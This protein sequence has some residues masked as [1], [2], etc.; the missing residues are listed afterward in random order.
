MYCLIISFTTTYERKKKG[1]MPSVDGEAGLP[2]HTGE[3]VSAA[4][5]S[6]YFGKQ[7]V[8]EGSSHNIRNDR[9]P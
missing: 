1:I 3:I 5:N 9:I 8:G 7:T 2:P 6:V 4:R